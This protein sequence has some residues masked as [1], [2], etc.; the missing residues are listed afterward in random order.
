MTRTIRPEATTDHEAIRHVHQFA[1]CQ[2]HEARIVNALRDEGYARVSLVAEVNGVV[3]GHILFSDLPILTDNDT[4][5]ALSL[6]PMAVLPEYQ[7]QG[8][9]SALVRKG[10]EVCR[11]QGHRIVIVL[12]HPSFYPRFGFSAKLA[13]PLSS[14]F[15]GRDSWM[16]L[17]LVPGA[18]EGIHGWV[19]YPPPFGLGEMT[20]T[21]LLALLRLFESAAIPVWLD[22]GWGV[23]ALLQTQTRKHRDVDIVLS[24]GD[25]S[26]LQRLLGTRGFCVREGKP[27]H[28]FVLADGAGLEVDVHAVTFDDDGNGV[29]RMQNDE[30]WVYPAEGFTGRG[31]VG[32]MVVRCLSATTQVLCHAHGYVPVEK[33]FSDMQRLEERFGVVL[34]P[35]L[36]RRSSKSTPS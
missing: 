12:G 3:V 18:L 14:P 20:Q 26:E 2:D 6:A 23:D 9:G 11:D 1:F 27:P 7:K 29:Y 25:V 30:D 32:G 24:V 22:G 31:L 21:A 15:G 8:I 5:W 13:E 16:A 34:P 35:Q 36:Q 19:R 17:E 4:I 10:L 33:D 28:S